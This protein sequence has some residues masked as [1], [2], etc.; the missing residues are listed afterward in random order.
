VSGL[1]ASVPGSIR[2]WHR[3]RGRDLLAFR[4]GIAKVP[5]TGYSTGYST[6]YMLGS[7]IASI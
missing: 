4:R 2:A 3:M 7:Q 1:L 6:G 5:G